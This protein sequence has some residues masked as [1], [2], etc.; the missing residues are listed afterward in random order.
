MMQAM[1]RRETPNRN[2]LIY[3]KLGENHF[4]V[5]PRRSELPTVHFAVEETQIAR[6]EPNRVPLGGPGGNEWGK[7]LT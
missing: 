3:F 5:I 1:Y 7:M 2:I 6:N 4:F